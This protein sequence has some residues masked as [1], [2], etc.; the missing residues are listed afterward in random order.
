MKKNNRPPAYPQVVPKGACMMEE[1]ECRHCHNF[2]DIPNSVT[3]GCT[4]THPVKW[5]CST[6]DCG[7]VFKII[8]HATNND[9][10]ISC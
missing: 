5:V 10:T 7:N 2:V 4:P 9:G 3:E 8:A 6:L 1:I